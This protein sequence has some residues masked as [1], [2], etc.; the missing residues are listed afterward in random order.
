MNKP[1][2]VKC[3]VSNLWYCGT[4][5][6]LYSENR[7]WW[8]WTTGIGTNPEMAYY[9]WCE[10]HHVNPVTRRVSLW[11]GVFNWIKRL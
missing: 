4:P 3:P 6:D 7:F 8:I 2:L 9:K 11:G 10:M 5:E 1:R